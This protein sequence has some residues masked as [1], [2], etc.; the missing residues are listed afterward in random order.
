MSDTTEMRIDVTVYYPNG[1]PAQVLRDV[2]VSEVDE[3]VE[4]WVTNTGLE[5]RAETVTTVTT[6]EPYVAC[7]YTYSHTQY[8]CGNVHCRVS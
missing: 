3:T 6:R 1:E 5:A 7:E 4:S 2:P 8:V